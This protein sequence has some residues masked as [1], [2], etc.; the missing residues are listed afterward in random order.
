M[1]EFITQ[2]SLGLL[3]SLDLHSVDS[4]FGNEKVKLD[5]WYYHSST[6]PPPEW[7]QR[8]VYVKDIWILSVSARAFSFSLLCINATKEDIFDVVT[9]VKVLEKQLI[10]LFLWKKSN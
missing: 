2:H 4:L 8:A 10:V 5:Y 1:W 9:S 3:T 7:S 6:D